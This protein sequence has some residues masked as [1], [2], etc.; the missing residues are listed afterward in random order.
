MDEQRETVGIALAVD[1]EHAGNASSHGEGAQDVAPPPRG[2]KTNT[3]RRGGGPA[4]KF[5]EFQTVGP[6]CRSPG[7]ESLPS[8]AGIPNY[9][10]KPVFKLL[11]NT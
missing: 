1:D 8:A 6:G 9:L 11:E 5:F 2:Q 3:V 4:R 10:S 7:A